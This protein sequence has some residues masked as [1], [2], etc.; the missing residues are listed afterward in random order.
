MNKETEN[1]FAEIDMYEW[2]CA[3]CGVVMHMPKDFNDQLRKS[4][5]TFY[6]LTGH[7]NVYNTKTDIE[8]VQ[9]KLM[10]EYAKNAQLEAEIKKL[11][12]SLVNRIL[13]PK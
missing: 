13:P 1:P 7:K 9:G 11:K 6:C 12:T 8:E 3:T 10:N 5:Q 2:S 4:H